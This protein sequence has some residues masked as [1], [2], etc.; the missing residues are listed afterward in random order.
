MNRPIYTLTLDYLE[1]CQA[2]EENP[3]FKGELIQDLYRSVGDC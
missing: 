1:H 2:L 3:R